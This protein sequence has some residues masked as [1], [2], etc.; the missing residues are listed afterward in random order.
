LDEF[1]DADG[2]FPVFEQ[3]QNP[4]LLLIRADIASRLFFE[5]VF[6]DGNS[7]EPKCFGGFQGYIAKPFFLSPTLESMIVPL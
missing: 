6:V 2:G 1:F 3:G 7:Y 5:A 4:L